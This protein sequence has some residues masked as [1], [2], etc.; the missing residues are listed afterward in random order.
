MKKKLTKGFYEI[1]AGVCFIL[2]G[3]GVYS[4]DKILGI[5]NITIGLIFFCVW[6]Y[7]LKKAKDLENGVMTKPAPTKSIP[8]KNIPKK[9][10][11]KK[12]K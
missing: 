10:V 7:E 9:N 11:S 12:K 1:L 6:A 4:S 5:F 2:L 8:S 3:I